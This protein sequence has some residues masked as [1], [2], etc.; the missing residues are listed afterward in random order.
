LAPDWSFAE[1]LKKE[2]GSERTVGPVQTFFFRAEDRPWSQGHM[3][4]L[5][6]VDTVI[7]LS[8]ERIRANIYPAVDVLTSRSRLIETKAVSNEYAITSERVRQAISILW[9]AGRRSRSNV[10]KLMF[11]R[12][13]KLQKLLHPAVFRRGAAH[14][15]SRR[16]RRRSGSAPHMPRDS[17][18]AL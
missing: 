17:R 16:N 12:A 14:Q 8:R 15:A 7:H 6:A 1:E 2:A 4:A 13:L 9:A 3:A 18:R 10:D 11:E 5:A